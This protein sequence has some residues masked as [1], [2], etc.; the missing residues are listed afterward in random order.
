MFVGNFNRKRC[1]I[2]AD[3][4]NKS[5]CVTGLSGSGKTCR[6]NKIELENINSDTTIIVLDTNHTHAE[7]QILPSIRKKYFE[8]ANRIDAVRDGIDLCI[9]QPLTNS[10][11][12]TESP[13]HLV[14][15]TVQ[16]FSTSQNL[17]VRQIAAL[18]EAVID[19]IKYR[20]DFNSDAEALNFCLSLR[21][22][23]PSETVRQRL[24]NLLNCGIL[25]PSKKSIMSSFIN[26][27]DFSEVDESTKISLSEL[28]LS[29]IWRNAQYGNLK[30][31]TKNL[32][33]ILDEFQNLSLKK[34]SLLRTML[35]EGRKFG[36]SLVLSTQTL[37]AFPKDLLSL[38]DQAA[39]KLYFRPAQNEALK[40]SK[41]IGSNEP[42]EFAKHLLNLHIGECIAVGN[43]CVGGTPVQRPILLK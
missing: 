20:S 18:R 17:G 38:L 37:A 28:T 35:R 29:S 5:I 41:E 12:E 2:S 6:L 27:L 34:D 39:T 22:D 25:R 1:E 23:T 3:S 43:F 8:I 31:F 7:E 14:N 4:P 15:S 10:K 32:I 19:A 16:A 24:W 40:I 36:I 33:I 13:L 9:F 21:D 30:T 42:K 11:N 26:I